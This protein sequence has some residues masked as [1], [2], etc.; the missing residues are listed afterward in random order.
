MQQPERAAHGL[1][2]V[3]L[4]HIWRYGDDTLG[5]ETTESLDPHGRSG[6]GDARL[7]TS[8]PCAASARDAPGP[9]RM[10][11]I[12]TT[13]TP[14][15]GR[16]PGPSGSIGLPATRRNAITGCCA[17]ACPCG[18]ARHSSSL[19]IC[20]ASWGSCPSCTLR[21]ETADPPPGR[22]RIAT[23]DHHKYSTSPA[24][25]FAKFERAKADLF[26]NAISSYVLQSIA[27]THL[28]H[29]RRAGQRITPFAPNVELQN[30]PRAHHAFGV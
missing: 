22:A 11:V 10:W 12:S 13:R 27:A 25:F 18:W 23:R 29:Q 5:I 6:Q 15:S 4:R 9:A 14:E 3:H 30:P 1:D 20:S 16:S 17:R 24:S 19:R 28:R 26:V 8:A 7:I 2:V 21:Y